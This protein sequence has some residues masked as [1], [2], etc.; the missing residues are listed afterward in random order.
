MTLKNNTELA[1]TRDKLRLLEDEYRETAKDLAEDPRVRQLSLQ[2]LK[3]L[4]NQLKEE[5]SRYQAC[6]PAQ[7]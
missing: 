2:S 6:Q 4:I 1:K 5:I 7:R 3:T